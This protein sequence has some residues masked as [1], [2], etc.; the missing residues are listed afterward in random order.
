MELRPEVFWKNV[1]KKAQFIRAADISN[2]T[3]LSRTTAGRMLRKCT[4]PKLSDAN[5]I[6]KALG[7]SLDELLQDEAVSV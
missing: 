7:C 4:M 6:A 2:V 1:K 5:K 3:G